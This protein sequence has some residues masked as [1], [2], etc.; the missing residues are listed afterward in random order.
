M[1]KLSL[2]GKGRLS[3]IMLIT[4]AVTALKEGTNSKDAAADTMMPARVPSSFFFLL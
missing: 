3:T 1:V 2:T 4:D